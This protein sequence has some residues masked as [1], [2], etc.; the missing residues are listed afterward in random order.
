MSDPLVGWQKLWF[1]LRNDAYMPLPVFTGSCPIPQ[2]DWGYGVAQKYIHRVQT[3]R[4]V[5]RRLLRGGLTGA[6]L[7]CTFISRRV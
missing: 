4:D 2:S 7:L 6:D 1:F 3:L 5:V